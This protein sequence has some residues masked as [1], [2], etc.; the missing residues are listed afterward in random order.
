[1]WGT[2]LWSVLRSGGD[3]RYLAYDSY[4]VIEQAENSITVQGEISWGYRRDLI[5]ERGYP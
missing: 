5:A 1:M 3:S 2:S 4:G